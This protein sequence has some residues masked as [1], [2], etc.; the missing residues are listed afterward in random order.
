M[1]FNSALSD[2]P[3]PHRL[4]LGASRLENLPPSVAA[5]FADPTWINLGD[6]T[7]PG[8]ESTALAKVRRH[9]AR[10]GWRAVPGD[11]LRELH[12]RA[13]RRTETPVAAT[14]FSAW[15]YRKGDRLAFDDSS[16]TFVFSEHLFEHLFFDEA[17]A[18]MRE[19]SRILKPGGIVRTVVPDADLRADLPPEPVGFPGRRVP[20]TDPNKHKTRWSVYMLSELLELTGLRPVPVRYFDKVGALTDLTSRDLAEVHKSLC[21]PRDGL[22]DPEPARRLDYI[23]RMNSLI[24]DGLKG[25]T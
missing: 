19:C 17:A 5:T 18:L 11:V 22:V 21:A 23:Q 10:Y 4:H 6:E 20:W 3:T 7:P 24:V 12:K 14:H 2:L 9:A 13:R 16:M 25:Q 15:V 1:T 8:Q